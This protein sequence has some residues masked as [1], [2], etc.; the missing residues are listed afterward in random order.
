MQE[1]LTLELESAILPS[2]HTKQRATKLQNKSGCITKENNTNLKE[3]EKLLRMLYTIKYNNWPGRYSGMLDGF[4]LY[5]NGDAL[6][7][8]E[9]REVCLKSLC[10]EQASYEVINNLV[11]QITI[12][13]NNAAAKNSL[14]NYDTDGRQYINYKDFGVYLKVYCEYIGRICVAYV[15]ECSS[16]TSHPL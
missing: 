7:T 16:D 12:A 1:N 14:I 4:F 8:D 5:W 11:F 15:V 10:G 9:F 3:S 2:Q 13:A 6:S